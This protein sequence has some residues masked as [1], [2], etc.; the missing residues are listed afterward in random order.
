[1]TRGICG[2]V[3]ALAA[4]AAGAEPVTLKAADGVVVHGEIWRAANPR[5]PLVVAFHQAG[6]SHAEY[7]PIAARLNAAGYSVLAIDQRSGGD[8]FAPN[9]TAAPFNQE[10]GYE[11]ALPDLEAAF[12][13]AKADAKGA[14]VV[15]W[16]SSYSSS[17]IFVLAAR[18]PQDIAGLLS[19]SPGEYFDDK[20][21]LVRKAAA[22]VTV[23]VF[24]D[25]ASTPDEI[26][27][28]AAILK[29]VKGSDKQQF[30]SKGA[31]VHGSS[32]LRSDR[33]AG[34][35]EPHWQAAMAFLRRVAPAAAAKPG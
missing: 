20:P 5:A 25:Q 34:A 32:T 29:A 23:P 21:D 33:N 14:K 27:A 22:Q 10:Q 15:L 28:S 30:I 8:L 4:F 18:H 13:W 7:T 2:A 16:G 1:M 9:A 31:S 12:G 11:A 3:L 35:I 24:I 17:L 19:F 6:S 26:A